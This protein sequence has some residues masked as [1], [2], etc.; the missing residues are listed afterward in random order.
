MAAR[1][2]W[3]GQLRLSLVSIAV[4]LY[5]ATR[6]GARISFRQIHEPSGKPIRYEKVAEGVGPV[7]KDEIAKGYQVDSGQYVLLSEEEVD[8]VKLETKRTFELIQF[9]GACEIP[10]LYF[11]KPYYLVPADELAHDAYRVVR[12]A[13]RNTETV[14]LGQVTLRG[15][16][17]I[18]AVRPCGDGLLLETLHYADELRQAHPLFREISGEKAEPDLL[19]VATAL[20]ERKRAPFDAKAFTDNYTTALKELVDRKLRSKRTRKVTAEERKREEAAA[21]RSNVVDLMSALKKSLEG[22]KPAAS[23]KATKPASGKAP[24]KKAAPKRKSA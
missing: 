15:R 8:A 13:L 24:A 2:I 1:P 22:S 4:E 19:E 17:Y 21:G 18:A 6:S 23:S 11:D 10:P 3:K 16:E 7:P 14:G 5:T 9:V 20:I 12:D